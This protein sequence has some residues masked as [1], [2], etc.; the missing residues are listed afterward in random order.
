[1][2]DLFF[3]LLTDIMHIFIT[4]LGFGN[5]SSHNTRGESV[6]THTSMYVGTPAS[7]FGSVGPASARSS[8]P[9]RAVPLL[10]GWEELL[11]FLFTSKYKRTTGTNKPLARSGR[12][13]F[14]S[15]RAEPDRIVEYKRARG[16]SPSIF[17]A[18]SFGFASYR[19]TT[20]RLS[21]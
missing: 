21:G 18:K 10:A 11:G 12:V 4:V 15:Q 19:T 5:E 8:A 3:V 7:R 13:A 17:S 2:R 16:A 1:M 6:C 20:M 9:L 14:L